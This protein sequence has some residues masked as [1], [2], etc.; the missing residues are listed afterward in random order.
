M[1][2]YDTIRIKQQMDSILPKDMWQEILQRC[3]FISK[4][5]LR[6]VNK[7]FYNELDVCDFMNM[8]KSHTLLT[9][10]ILKK[11]KNVKYLCI[12]G[13][14][15]SNTALSNLTNLKILKICGM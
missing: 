14:Q 6:Q 1:A 2:Q 4:I 8:K 15:I 3:N 7:Q 10:E 12:D 9:N 5:R 11:H 13:I